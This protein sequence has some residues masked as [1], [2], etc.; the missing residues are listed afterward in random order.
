MI[1]VWMALTFSQVTE[2]QK[3]L[4]LCSHSVVKLREAT[5][6]FL[7]VDNVKGMTSKKSFKYGE[8]GSFDY[9]IILFPS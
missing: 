5:Q 1:P 2:L 4:N 8:C 7:L 6:M 9:F 3:R